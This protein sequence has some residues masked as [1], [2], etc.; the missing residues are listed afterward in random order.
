MSAPAK[1][2]LHQSIG[3]QMSVTSRLQ[4][5]RLDENLKAIGLT[6]I[7]W[8]ILLAVDNEQLVHP[9]DIAEF[10]GID[11][12]ATSRALRGMEN[13]G[14]IARQAG[15]NDRRMRAVEMTEHGIGLLK[16]ATPFAN[17]SNAVIQ[18]ALTAGELIG[19]R[20]VLAK[21]RDIEDK[22]LPRL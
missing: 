13:A 5:R 18:K 17:S 9:S 8:C 2:R 11:R 1:Y 3:Y 7:Y 14:M 22:P 21:L 20:Q 10:V 6:R 15:G 12:T 16:Q 19:L 4:E